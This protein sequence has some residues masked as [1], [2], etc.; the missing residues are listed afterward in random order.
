MSP[1]ALDA[2]ELSVPQRCM[3]V[4]DVLARIG[5][6]WAVMI[7]MTLGAGPHRFNDLKRAIGGISQRMLTLTLRKLERDGLVGRTV[8]ADIPPHVEYALTAL[9]H[10]LRGPA[11]AL[12][13]WAMQHQSEVA[14][15]REQFDARKA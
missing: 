8:T 10:S 1:P 9:G 13:S 7:I 14:R 4:S 3:L 6:R 5:D 12:G 11:E 15:M 2:R